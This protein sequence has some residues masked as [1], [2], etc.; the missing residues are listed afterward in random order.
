[1][2]RPILVIQVEDGTDNLLTKTDLSITLATLENA[3]GR[4]LREG[5]VAHTFNDIVDLEVNGRRVRRIDASRIEEDR[6]IGV[7][8][9][10][11]SLSTGW[12]CPRA[13]VMMSFPAGA[14]SHLHR[15]ASRAHG[16][17]AAGAPGRGRRCSE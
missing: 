9:F 5:E 10:K 8:L 6:N 15:T 13:E 2:V 14:G 11:M 7:V 4:P 3:I 12:D 16:A 1:M 17:D